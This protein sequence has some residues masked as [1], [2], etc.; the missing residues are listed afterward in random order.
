MNDLFRP[1]ETEEKRGNEIKNNDTWIK[2]ATNRERWKALESECATTAA[3]ISVDSE[4]LRKIQ[5]DQHAP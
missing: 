5:S 3:G 4:I 2:V 1:E